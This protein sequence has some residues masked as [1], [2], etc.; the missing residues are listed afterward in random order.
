VTAITFWRNR[1]NFAVTRANGLTASVGA[2][3][4]AGRR[5]RRRG[6]R[7]GRKDKGAAILDCA[8]DNR[9][10]T[11]EG[12]MGGRLFSQRPRRPL[13]PGF[14]TSNDGRVRPNFG[15]Q[16]ALDA[17]LCGI[18]RRLGLGRALFGNLEAH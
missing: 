16:S 3:T 5:L 11:G 17:I 13:V 14:E 8:L 2:L 4:I 9:P 1:K 12:E 10:S 7:R 6:R 18:R 15:A